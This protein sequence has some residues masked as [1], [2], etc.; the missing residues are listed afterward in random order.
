MPEPLLTATV[1]NQAAV[2]QKMALQLAP[3]GLELLAH[4]FVA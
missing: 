3:Q 4:W 1:P 2:I